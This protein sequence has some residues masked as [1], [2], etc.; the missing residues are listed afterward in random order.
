M[1]PN[2][3]SILK[4]QDSPL[5]K[6]Y[7]E[8]QLHRIFEKNAAQSPDNTALIFEE[9]DKDTLVITNETYSELN[10]ASN[11]LARALLHFLHT[12]AVPNEN[13]E[14]DHIVA[15][16]LA[17]S[18]GLIQV[19]LAVWKA[20]AAYLPL[21]VTAPEQRV[22][23]ILN[24]A[25]P[26]LVIAEN[27]QA[28]ENPAY[29]GRTVLSLPQLR[30][31]SASLSHNNIPGESM[32]HSDNNNE[33]SN[34]IA[35]V[36]YTSGSTG[37]PKGVRLPHEVIL[38]RLAWQ[39]ATFPYSPSERVGAFKTA[40]T[41]V[42]AVSEIW[43]PLL[44]AR[45]GGVLIIPRDVTRNPD[46]LIGT[47]EKYKVERLVL[48]PSL[49]RSMLMFLK[50]TGT[51]A[52][53]KIPLSNLKLWVCSGET[54]SRSLCLEFF[55]HFDQYGHQ[56]PAHALCNFYG[57]TEVMGD[58]TYYE[59]RN[60]QD[61]QRYEKIPIG[62]AIDNT[63]I[64][65]LDTQQKPVPL[66]DVGEIYA[67]GRN[68]A[69][70]YV[71]G[72]DPDRF[73]VNNFTSNNEYR[74]MYKTG[75]YGRIVDDILLYEGRTDSQVKIRGN[76]VDLSEVEAA[77]SKL[78][79]V[80]KLSVLCNKPG[81]VDQVSE[82][83]R[84]DLSE[85]TSE[86][87]RVD[88]SKVDKLSVLCYK[89]GEV[90]QALLAF[91]T[92]HSDADNI[93]SFDIEAKLS[94]YLNPYSIPQVIIKDSIPLLINGKIDRQALLR[95]YAEIAD[96]STAVQIDYTGIGSDR[97]PVAKVLFETVVQVL[98]S[99]V[100]SHVSQSVNFYQIGGNSL[101]SIY[102]ITKLREA[103][104]QVSVADFVSAQTL[105]D[106]IDLILS[107]KAHPGISLSN[108]YECVFLTHAHK[109]DLF[110]I[111]TDS[112]YEKA[113]LERWIIPELKRDCYVELLEQIWEPLV[114]A[115]LSFIVKSR[116]VGEGGKILGACLNFDALDEPEVAITSKLNI[117]F[118]FLEHL[119]GPIRE[120]QLPKEKGTILHSF[121]MGTEKSLNGKENVQIITAMEEEILRIA[122]D[123]QFHGILT[124]NTNPLTQQLGVDVFNYQVLLDYPVNQF[125]A[126]DGTKPFGQADN[127]QRAI[128]CWKKVI[129]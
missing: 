110:Q 82:E 2:Y 69:A 91:V 115:R 39:W 103:G 47:L 119:E 38:N 88:I 55:Q 81:E 29:K 114:A 87:R 63:H 37:I 105:G 72:R 65:L 14:G 57:S 124:T 71:N 31:L 80:D 28:C 51:N 95:S 128:V 123:R 6:I 112:F 50:M 22:K 97:L 49:L 5:E 107:N 60:S 36:L 3:L 85:V 20:G 120:S 106:I 90:D 8:K 118:E 96:N 19:L 52:D 30:L 11:Q 64:F 92:L 59:M 108:Q 32:L 93:T 9:Q 117:I 125:V 27:E 101:N 111:I 23:H 75:D 84:V 1:D 83:R 21:D 33:Q 43:G 74:R 46:Q 109:Q 10:S 26:L 66:G 16:S 4:G 15:V 129:S 86:E 18:S 126:S 24:E 53:S 94:E 100:R 76:R 116:E 34:D 40:L 45:C 77:L 104:H 73:I 61:A 7:K 41:F 68:I 113:D 13:Q 12:K 42:D 56:I 79:E 98:G 70:G 121:M 25:R 35:I 58:V 127:S 44:S 62:K 122:K 54:L 67:C 17:P 102:T 78:S 48:V 99:S 89:P